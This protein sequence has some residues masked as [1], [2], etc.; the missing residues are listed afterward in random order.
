MQQCMAVGVKKLCIFINGH[1]YSETNT[2]GE[3]AWGEFQIDGAIFKCTLVWGRKLAVLRRQDHGV[4]WAVSLVCVTE[5]SE[6]CN[7]A[8]YISCQGQV[9]ARTGTTSKVT[10]AIVA[11]RRRYEATTR[12]RDIDPARDCIQTGAHSLSN[13][14]RHTVV[15]DCMEYTTEWA[16]PNSRSSREKK[17]LGA[18]PPYSWEPTSRNSRNR[19]RET[20]P[21]AICMQQEKGDEF[22]WGTFFLLVGIAIMCDKAIQ[23]V[24]IRPTRFQTVFFIVQLQL[25][26]VRLSR[27]Q[28]T[29]ARCGRFLT[30]KAR[31]SHAGSSATQQPKERWLAVPCERGDG[32]SQICCAKR[33]S[34]GALKK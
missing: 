23:A 32:C 16:K 8:L 34:K 13:A 30:A 18:T 24:L 12:A 25:N 15:L 11:G 21:L 29:G 20:Q 4:R 33:V 31:A 10:C 22:E 19:G 6:V 2:L 5:V 27:Q 3:Y 28:R 7:L 9:V 14:D 26:G 17:K 1:G